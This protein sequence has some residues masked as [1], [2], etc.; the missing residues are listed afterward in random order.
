MLDTFLNV[1]HQPTIL[2]IETG[3]EEFKL[4][5]FL[6]VVKEVTEDDQY[7]TKTMSKS[8]YHLPELIM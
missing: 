3:S 2:R 8:D 4:P 5:E 6:K 1:D 7:K